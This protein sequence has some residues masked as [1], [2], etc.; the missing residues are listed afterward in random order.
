MDETVRELV[1]ADR[2]TLCRRR[3]NLVV[4]AF[5]LGRAQ[6]LLML[7]FE[8]CERGELDGAQR[9][10]GLPA[11]AAGDRRDARA[12]RDARPGGRPLRARRC[13]G[14]ACPTACVSR[15]TPEESMAINKIRSGAIVIAASGMCEAG[16]I[17][18]HLRHNL[19][20]EECAILFT[21]FQAGGTLG[22]R[23]VDGARSVRLFGETIPVRARIHTLGGLSAHADRRALLALARRVPA[24]AVADLRGPRR[25][26]DGARLRR[27]RPGSTL[28]G[29]RRVP[30][31]RRGGRLLRPAPARSRRSCY[32]FAARCNTTP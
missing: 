14:A 1:G 7:L 4:P 30:G 16:R 15:R 32:P 22:R 12:P 20:R 25:G 3:G 13:A 23:L 18:H 19:G 21:G 29:G 24:P 6:E 26:I 11:R 17:R 8:L 5:A 10:R 2:E 9:V 31:R 27:S 28:A